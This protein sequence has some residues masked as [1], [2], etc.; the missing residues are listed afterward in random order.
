MAR[1]D[2]MSRRRKFIGALLQLDPVAADGMLG[3]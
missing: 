3:I 2:R 1:L